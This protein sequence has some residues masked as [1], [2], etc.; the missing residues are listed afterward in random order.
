MLTKNTRKSIERHADI[1]GGISKGQT[2]VLLAHIDRLHDLLEE[3]LTFGEEWGEEE[4]SIF[5]RATL[6]LIDGWTVRT[7]RGTRA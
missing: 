6:P 2:Y 4:W 1:G 7:K 5:T 3:V